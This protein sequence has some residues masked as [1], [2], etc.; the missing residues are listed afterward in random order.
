[1]NSEQ[2]AEYLTHLDHPTQLPLSAN[3]PS[4]YWLYQEHVRR[5]PYQNLDLFMNKPMRDLSFSSLLK[6]VAI[7]GR[8]YRYFNFSNPFKE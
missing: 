7:Q 5:F 1:M 8:I 3:I 2:F 4:L 6:S